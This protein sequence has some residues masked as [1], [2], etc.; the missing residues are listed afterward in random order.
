MRK[1]KRQRF[2]S[3]REAYKS[4]FSYFTMP[5]MFAG[6]G[7]YIVVWWSEH[8]A[9][10]YEHAK[11]SI[12][13]VGFLSL[14]ILA[15]SWYKAFLAVSAIMG[16]EFDN[17][18]DI[19]ETVICISCREAF[20]GTDIKASKCPKCGGRLEDLKGFFERHPEPK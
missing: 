18:P 13:F 6:F 2:A 1:Q 15:Y 10:S 17:F 7:I 9:V 4:F 20:P 11:N 19:P 5:Y 16:R 8:G 12:Y 14:I 3:K